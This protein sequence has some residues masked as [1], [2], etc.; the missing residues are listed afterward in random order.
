MAPTGPDDV[1][2]DVPDE[3]PADVAALAE[4]DAG[5]PDTGAAA[6]ARA[7]AD[8]RAAAVLDAQAATRAELAA[9]PAPEVPPEV[10]ARWSAALAAEAAGAPPPRGAATARSADPATAA[11][12]PRTTGRRT[13]GSAPRTGGPCPRSGRAP[14]WRPLLVAAALAAVVG[15]GLGA[16]VPHEAPGP[17]VTRVELVALGR[18]AIGTMDVGELADAGRRAACL[19]AVAPDAVGEELL[20]GRRVV[21]D[22]RPGVLLVLARGTV[23]AL[24]I[25]TVDPG[26]G[27]PAGGALRAESLVG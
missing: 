23:G 16:L 14:A 5:L 4:L 20:G 1:P 13:R 22:G 8:P 10:A 12:G 2:R 15:T 24:R 7:A 27:G 6:R 3:V 21:L 11:A 25:L 19:R 26:C 18:A 17:A 9:H